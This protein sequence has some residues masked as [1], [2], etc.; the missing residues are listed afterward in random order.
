MRGAGAILATFGVSDAAIMDV[1]TGQFKPTGK[2]PFAL[3][4]SAE[5]IVEQAAAAPGHDEEDT[6]SSPSAT[7]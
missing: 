6:R 3:A 5:A 4:R 2:L 1:L 7:D